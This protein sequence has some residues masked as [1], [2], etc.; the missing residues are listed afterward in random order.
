MW[1]RTILFKLAVS[2]VVVLLMALAAELV[3]RLRGYAPIYDVIRERPARQHEMSLILREADAPLLTYD[4]VPNSR[5]RVWNTVVEINS[6]G[7]RD[8][9]YARE[10]PAGVERIIALGDSVTFGNG[11]PVEATWPEV[12]ERLLAQDAKGPRFDVLNLGV[13]GYNTLEEVGFLEAR[14]LAYEPDRVIVCYHVNDLGGISISRPIL[15]GVRRYRSPLYR[16]RLAQLVRVK[17]DEWELRGQQEAANHEATFAEEY[18]DHIDDLSGDGELAASVI[19]LAKR[20]EARGELPGGREYLWWYTSPN[21]IGRLRHAFRRLAQRSQEH[22]FAVDVLILP[23]LESGDYEAE[24]ELI[25][26][27]AGHEAARA[28][29]GVLPLLETFRRAPGEDPGGDPWHPNA[30]GHE[31]IARDVLH[32]LSSGA[33]REAANGR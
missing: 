13:T 20:L 28:G 18:R 5:G 16:S 17:L 33:G 2:G 15:R 22:G 12:L 4:L 3:L 30:R 6:G 9:E 25:Y 11:L 7:F 21:R 27:I 10:K 8:V 23:C 24:Y 19:A 29:F 1:R 32:Y 14:G 26:A 31:L